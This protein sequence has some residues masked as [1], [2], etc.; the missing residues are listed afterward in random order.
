[1]GFPAAHEEREKELTS[2]LPGHL[3]FRKHYSNHQATIQISTTHHYPL[4]QEF[5]GY[6]AVLGTT[7][8]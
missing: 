6:W 8:D 2:I 1:M 7:V 4:I 3:E 5:V